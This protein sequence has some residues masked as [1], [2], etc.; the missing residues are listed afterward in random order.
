MISPNFRDKD[1]LEEVK[2][3]GGDTYYEENPTNINAIILKGGV[4]H[5]GYEECKGTT[6]Y[7]YVTRINSGGKPI[8]LD[9][10]GLY[11]IYPDNPGTV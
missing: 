9:A 3:R 4:V 7:D 8:G 5:F 10:N 1:A 11:S 2:K 6:I